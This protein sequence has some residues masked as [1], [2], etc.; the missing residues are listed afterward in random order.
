MQVDAQRYL[1]LLEKNRSLL[2]VDIEAS[3][4]KGD[5]NSVLVV[6]TKPYGARAESL[7]VKNVG[8]DK[9]VLV[10]AKK[11]LE[12]ADC[13]VT[14]YGKGFDI[15]MLNTRLLRHG[16]LPIEKRHHVDMYYVLKY[17]I[18]TGRKSQGH[19]LSWLKL[20]QQKMSVSA[21]DWSDMPSN[22]EELMPTMIRRC[23]SD[24]RGLEALYKRTRHLIKDITK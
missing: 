19:L 10:E 16:L 14:Y 24:V 21:S 23:E 8:S 13:W 15:P 3:G 4:L 9:Q 17:G 12:G 2:F 5:Y 1:D 6:S 20:P 22:T 18:L 7:R 11:L